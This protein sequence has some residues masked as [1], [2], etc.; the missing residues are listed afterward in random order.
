MRSRL[1]TPSVRSAPT[2]AFDVETKDRRLSYME[3]RSLANDTAGE[4]TPGHRAPARSRSS[5]R[6][7]WTGV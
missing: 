3:A 7:A 2:R 4:F 1:A 5:A 6:H